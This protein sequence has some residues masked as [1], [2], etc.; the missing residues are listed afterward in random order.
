VSPTGRA[1]AGLA[2]IAAGAVVV[3]V[4]WALLAALALAAA[5][6]VDALAVRRPPVVTRV[7]PGSL[8]RAVPATVEIGV[9]APAAAAGVRVRQPVPPDL[10]IDPY[11]S[12]APLRARLVARRRGRHPL[13]AA[14]V[15]LTGPLGL[16]RWDHHGGGETEV[17]VYPDVPAARRL[18]LAVR[19]GLLQGASRRT[20]GP[21][22]LGTEFESIR[23]YI[24]GDDVRQVNWPATQRFERPMSNQYRVDQDRDVVC[25]VDT[26]RLMGAPVGDRT[27]LDAALDA[28]VAVALVADV[29]GDRCGAV[30]FDRE[31]HRRIAPRRANGEAVVRG[32]FDLEPRSVDSDYELAFHVA[33]RTK[34]SLVLVCTD[35]LDDSA[36]RSLVEAVP[37][38][39]RRH[40]VVVASVTDPDIDELVRTLPESTA[41]VYRAAVA[42]D[43]LAARSRVVA[44]IRRA[45]ADVV[46]APPDRLAA[47]CVDAYL[48]LKARMRV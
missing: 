19:R 31:V 37:V 8:A 14:R 25:V 12:G 46:E 28:V 4:P 32:L 2:A 45:G 39:A 30:A 17:I 35:L 36:A 20:R 43:V 15:R 24:P 1:A 48:R 3:P 18:A 27:R 44:S 47:A 41:D 11:D 13:P 33:G 6:V 22:G 29:V 7:A 42:V 21:L 26:G 16:G 40:A 9:D 38:L 5:T 10:A 34:R 23:E